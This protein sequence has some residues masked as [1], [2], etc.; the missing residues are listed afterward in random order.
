[1][2]RKP[3]KGQHVRVTDEIPVLDQPSLYMAKWR[4][5]LVDVILLSQNQD[6]TYSDYGQLK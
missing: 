1:M 3:I 4:S 5:K 2:P 6:G